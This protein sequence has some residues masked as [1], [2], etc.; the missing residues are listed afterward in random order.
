MHKTNSY[1]L[2]LNNFK[3][4]NFNLNNKTNDE[5]GRKKSGRKEDK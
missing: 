1:Y 2:V 5:R 3:V 4:E